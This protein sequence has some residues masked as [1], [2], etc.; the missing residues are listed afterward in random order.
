MNR[1]RSYLLTASLLVPLSALAPAQQVTG[2][3]RPNSVPLWT[4]TANP[5]TT[6]GN[7]SISENPTTKAITIGG[8][9]QVNGNLSAS[10]LSGPLATLLYHASFQGASPSTSG[11]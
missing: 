1:L 10:Q 9:L 6:Q 4:G 7:S 8:G 11:N 2:S 3:G 5:S